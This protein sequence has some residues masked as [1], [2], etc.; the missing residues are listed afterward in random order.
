MIAKTFKNGQK[1]RYSFQVTSEPG[2]RSYS[3]RHGTGTVVQ[4]T[5]PNVY[6]VKTPRGLLKRLFDTELRAIPTSA[7]SRRRNEAEGR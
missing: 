4:R 5:A 6:I 1:V 2:G 7:R 3:H